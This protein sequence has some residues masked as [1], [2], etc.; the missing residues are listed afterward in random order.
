MDKSVT[1]KLPRPYFIEEEPLKEFAPDFPFI[2]QFWN[3]PDIYE[4]NF[5]HE[6]RWFKTIPEYQKIETFLKQY[7]I[8]TDANLYFFAVTYHRLYDFMQHY[9]SKKHVAELKEHNDELE[10]LKQFLN[11][12]DETTICEIIF[13]GVSKDISLQIKNKSLLSEI[14][15]GIYDS[16]AGI[17]VIPLNIK[18]EKGYFSWFVQYTMPLFKYINATVFKS[19]KTNTMSYKFVEDFLS[20]LGVDFEKHVSKEIITTSYIKDRYKE[21]NTKNK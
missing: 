5:K 17:E 12:N 6:F 18:S 13:R 3:C 20:C 10:K 19:N 14:Y 4:R 16:Y 15:S 9:K 8:D 21:V 2:R 1:L 7:K 11:A